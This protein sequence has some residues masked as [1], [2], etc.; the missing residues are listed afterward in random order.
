MNIRKSCSLLSILLICGT[1]TLLS[2][3]L[4]SDIAGLQLWLDA[5]KGIT[6]NPEGNV[7]S[8]LDQG[9]HSPQRSAFASTTNSGTTP[10]FIPPPTYNATGGH[11]GTPTIDFNN[12]Q[13]VLQVSSSVN[14]SIVTEFTAF[15]VLSLNSWESQYL[16]DNKNRG[17][18]NRGFYLRAYT[19]GSNPSLQFRAYD[20]NGDQKTM[21]NTDMTIT[22]NSYELGDFIVTMISL[23]SEGVMTIR[24]GDQVHISDRDHSITSI[25]GSTPLSL[26]GV[27]YGASGNLDGSISSALFY[28]RALNSQEIEDVYGY[29]T[30]THIPEP[31][32]WGALGAGLLVCV[33]FRKKILRS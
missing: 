25:M 1:S 20:Q 27:V 22:T 31:S 17:T 33:L 7:T 10:Q 13:N 9:N 11:Q 5:S 8:W 4:P 14:S 6:T 16:I 30:Q 12:G 24:F 2:S 26:G 3:T 15:M 32:T 23:N 18:T 29:L 28:N 19:S 21:L